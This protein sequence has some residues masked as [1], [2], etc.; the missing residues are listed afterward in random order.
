MSTC[1]VIQPFDE[2]RFDKRYEDVFIPAI[3]AAE[4]EPYRVDRDPSAT[5]P[6]D[7]IE[8][9]IRRS[10]ACLADISTNNPNV[11]FELGFAI[12]S[13]KPVVLVCEHED[14]RRFPFDVQHRSI[15]SYKS[16]S[17]RDFD[18]LRREITKRLKATMA[19]ES[20]I[21]RLA[22]STHIADVGG[23]NQH[24][25]VALVTIA[26]NVSTPEDSVAAY[27]IRSD[28]ERAGYTKIAGTLALTGL[29]RKGLI[30]PST[31]H[32]E[33]GD[34][35]KVYSLTEDGMS[36]LM[37]NQDR[38]VLTLRGEEKADGEDSEIPF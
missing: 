15:I 21:D 20:T 18:G 3:Q 11:W 1:F 25:L 13:T 36:W 2:G 5:I 30:Q 12:A 22:Q 4:L 26:E 24:E 9:G 10:D 14:G 29:F 8:E 17:A 32:S 34:P 33:Y 35:F 27:T 16:E 37:S 7:Q 31:E 28:M 38:I 23:L 19:K 6:I